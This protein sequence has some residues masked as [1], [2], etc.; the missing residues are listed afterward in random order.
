[1]TA[2]DIKGYCTLCRSRCGTINQVDQDRLIS[3]R[4]DPDHPNGS[5]MCMKGKAAPEIVHS[6]FRLTHPMKRT[7]PK[8][9]PDPGWVRISWEEALSTTASRLAAVRAESGAEAV[10]FAVTTPSG[11][12]LSDS[13]DWIER[14]VRLFG[15]PNTV[16]ATEVCNWHK[17]HAHVFTF[18]CGL[19]PPDY[20][21]ADTIV[22]WGH[23]PTNTWL[24]QANKIGIGRA[25]GAKLVVVDPRPTAL[26]KEADLWLQVRPGTDTVLAMAISQ[27]LIDAG[28]YDNAFVRCWTNSPF[29]VRVDTGEFL[30]ENMLWP[31]V[32]TDR[33]L[34]W[35]SHQAAPVPYDPARALSEGQAASLLLDGRVT[36]PCSTGGK[37]IE[38]ETAFSAFRRQTRQYSAEQVTE[39]T[40]VPADKID[41]AVAFFAGDKRIAYYSWNGVGQHTNATQTD[42]ALATLYALNGSFDKIG[43][44]RVRHGPPTASLAPM[45]LLS[46]TQRAKA[47]GIDARPIGPP[48]QG[49]VMARDVYQAVLE[50]KPYAIRAM[51][52]FGTNVRLSHSDTD[53]ARQALE[54]LEF[55]VHL[56]LFE[57]PSL[58]Y[59]D[60]V[61]PVNS[62]WEHEGLRMG[63]EI[64]DDAASHMQFRPRMV[65]PRG[66]SRSD[67]EIVFDLA[68]RLG[69]ADEFFGGDLRAGWAHYLAPSGIDLEQ[70]ACAPGGLRMPV[71]AAE[72]KY[73]RPDPARGGA[74]PGF[75]TPT[76]RVEIY[77]ERLLKHGQPAV[78]TYLPGAEDRRER[79]QR[80]ASE[81]PL[82]LSSAKN[83]YYCHSQHRGLAS[84]RK[85]A[86]DPTAEISPRL[87]ASRGLKD[88]DWMQISS[89]V[90]QA[91]FVV[92]ITP[93]LADDMVVA[94][95]GWWEACTA[96]ARDA[97]P[98][99]G[100]LSSNFNSLISADQH[101][102]VSGSIAMRSFRCE[103]APDPATLAGQ[104][105]WEGWRDFKV[106]A[107]VQEAAGVLGI[108]LEPAEAGPLPDFLPGQHVQIRVH[109]G[110]QTL[111]RAYSLTGPAVWPGRRGYSIAVRHQ[112]GRDINGREFE[113]AVSSYL[114]RHLALGHKIELM[115]P[116]GSFML[117]VRSEQPLV[118]LAGGIGIT[119]FINL[120]ETLPDGD[121]LE[122]WLYYANLNSRSHAFRQRIAE[123]RK[124][125][126]GLKV[127][128]V[129]ASPLDTDVAGV[130][131]AS[132]GFITADVVSDALIARR[133]RVY[134][135][136]PPA[137]MDSF[138][139]GLIVRGVPRFD[140]FREVF[141]SPPGPVEDDGRTFSVRF[142]RSLQD[143]TVW[144]AKDGCLLPFGETLGAK[145]PSGCRVGQ[146]ESCAV[147]IVSG[148]VRH[149]HGVEPDEAD[150]CLTCQAVP[151]S[152]LVLDA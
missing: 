110:L 6:P 131:Y 98:I 80:G 8:T 10:A 7:R 81:F 136:G 25:R 56:D 135:C 33:N 90:G 27:R 88:G 113:G 3:V 126:P 30:R 84:L 12:P 58:R 38:C 127:L 5:A 128:D 150:V 2:T 107:L 138:A 125:L 26:A 149:L 93:G 18:G 114:H 50:A 134:M 54:K 35:D 94:E 132:T 99:G 145:L 116:S 37:A 42:R 40:G 133:A 111:G 71:D 75:D 129:Y 105:G 34:V 141:R 1:M 9:D 79:Q 23:N 62:P 82:L 124:R 120:L 73:G 104:R 45:S 109:D 48:S 119:P 70:L 152:D 139:N 78:P 32:E 39:I 68:T 85:R 46:D 87:A 53:I 52:A 61:L 17:D 51:M 76:G 13:I 41:A 118:L 121:P 115:A 55:H 148:K 74:V 137:M 28:L 108:H 92:K 97:L 16:Y 66:E 49:W 24:A 22:L 142:A 130:D 4:P 21:N 100:A 72:R 63:F 96:L 47:L 140:I 29:L 67:N 31:D 144:A 117:P 77:S 95:Y 102:P 59:A 122:M 151:V 44:N 15:S 65:S 143:S 112:K 106:S 147:R 19:Q 64:D 146:C 123:H 57:T 60:I 89:R 83:G 101:D 43:G 11:T 14:F 36:V 69:M 103:I 86:P 91:R 20:A